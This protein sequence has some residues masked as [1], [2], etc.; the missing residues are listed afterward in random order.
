MKRGNLILIIG[1]ITLNLLFCND[2]FS[3]KKIAIGPN[4]GEIYFIGPT[5]TYGGLYYSTD[6]GETAVCVDNTI[7]VYTLSLA[8]DKTIG[9]VYYATM[10]QALYYSPN[11]GN[12]G[13]WQLQSG[14]ILGILNSGVSEGFIY[15]HITK[16]SENYGDDFIYHTC[17][18]FFGSPI[19]TEIDT[20]QDIGYCISSHWNIIDT[21]YFF[22]S[23]DNFNNLTLL[24]KFN[25]MNGEQVE[26]S[27]GNNSGSVYLF[28]KTRKNLYFSDNYG[29][30]FNV[31]E[32]FNLPDDFYSYYITG[33]RQTGELYIIYNFGS[34]MWQNAHIYIFHSTDYG[35]TFEVF[36]PFA[37]GQEP[38]L[39][40]F[41]TP[42]KEGNQPLTVEFCNFSVGN[43]QEYQWDFDNDGVIDSY[44]ESPTWTY[45]NTGYYSVKLTLVGPDSS[46]AF[47]KENYITVL[48]GNS[49]EI[50]LNT[51]YQFISS[52][53]SPENPDMFEVLENNLNANL[54]FVRNSQGQML[55][56]IGGNWVNG[57]GDWISTEGYLFKMN[58]A[59]VLTIA[60]LAVNPQ[61]PI[62]LNTGYQFVSYLPNETLD[63]L[64]AF[65]SI[66]NDD[67]DF[68]R[69]SAG[70]VLQKIGPNWVNGIGD[71]NPGEGFLIK[72]NGEGVLQ[73]P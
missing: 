9:G 19:S 38:V 12:Q 30:T 25:F 63:A 31:I 52:N 22:I 27:R 33:G 24:T 14:S 49:Q 18:G 29:E 48:S 8:A 43:I 59:D 37:K 72:M 47:V 56:N 5:N 4:I 15:N 28:N 10:Y 1:I 39:S 64:E 41:S 6:F 51:G 21:M 20:Q 67:L 55:Q 26:L 53:R 60:G 3:Q 68:I 58:E 73:Y 34:M 70:Y 50:D 65:A 36:H 62:N 17:N 7:N 54:D 61:T 71:C 57:I 13:S 35:V 40:N 44:E 16:H 23:Y 32:K 2:G 11:Y 69:N 42:V 46:N 45:Q 66:L